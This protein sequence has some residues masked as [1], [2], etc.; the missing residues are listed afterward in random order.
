[1]KSIFI[2]VMVLL[3]SVMAGAADDKGGVDV[4]AGQ[5]FI[6]KKTPEAELPLY[7]F[8]PEEKSDAPRAAIVF[9]FGGG[10]SGGTPMQFVPHCEYLRTRGMVSIVVE[11]RVGSRHKV[12]ANA[13]VEDAKSAMRWVRTHAKEL[14]VDPERI[15][16]GGGSAGG[17]LA[18]CTGIIEGFEATDEDLSVSSRPNAMALFNPA[19]VLAP[20]PEMAVDEK[21]LNRL[22]E[23]MG[24]E[25]KLLSPY[26]HLK[27]GVVPT[28]IFHGKIDTTVPYHT[29]EIFTQR[30]VELGN[31]C[32]LFGY[33]KEKHGFFNFGRGDG[34]MFIETVTALDAFLVDL[35]YI[36]GKA[37]VEAFAKAYKKD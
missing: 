30:M 24:V 25:P 31:H 23:R 15:V 26:H 5:K 9:F 35:G 13:C 17:H 12:K 34:T 7:V 4:P 29:V 2:G 20:V 16:A 33:A 37:N 6:Y 1:M 10:W 19:M 22:P 36:E 3:V 27:K 11:Y 18:A 32:D 21:K 8:A 14:G 28:I